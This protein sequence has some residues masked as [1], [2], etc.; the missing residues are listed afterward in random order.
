MGILREKMLRDMTVRN[1][2][3]KTIKSYLNSV[4]DLAKHYMISPDR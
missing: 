1:F 3:A 4:Q 2:R